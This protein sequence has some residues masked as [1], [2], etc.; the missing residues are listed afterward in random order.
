VFGGPD[1]GCCA[2]ARGCR[3]WWEC[4]CGEAGSAAGLPSGRM[5]EVCDRVAR[6]EGA[7]GK[8]GE[9]SNVVVLLTTAGVLGPRGA[10]GARRKLVELRLLPRDWA[11]TRPSEVA[12][13][14]EPA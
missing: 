10:L 9:E 1:R 7:A 8:R 14:L 4:E 6:G 11:S 12:L 2:S 5:G 3:W 13:N